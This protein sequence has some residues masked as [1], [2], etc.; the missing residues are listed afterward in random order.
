MSSL[1]RSIALGLLLAASGAQAAPWTY[2]GTLSDNGAPANGRY[3]IRLS[4]LD[5]AGAKALAYPLTFSGVE[6]K[7]GAFA[8]DVDFGVDL[9][10]FGAVKLKTEVAQGG[11][12]FVALGE[13]QAFDAKGL[14][15]LAIT[16]PLDRI[17][18]EAPD[19]L[20]IRDG[21]R[22][23]TIE[24]TGFPE[25][26]VWNPGVDGVRSRTDFADGDEQRMLCVEAARIAVPVRLAPG[27]VWS[28]TQRI[29]AG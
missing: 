27:D 28:A 13:P 26:V 21:E 1:A 29:T 9:G 19:R 18:F 14:P 10:Q 11:S 6:V 2:R 4:V 16:G 12:G 24:K 25:A 15:V 22:Q 7:D 3:D 17:Y 20:V 5:A 8:V 23:L